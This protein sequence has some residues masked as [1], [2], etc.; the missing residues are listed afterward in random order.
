LE[1]QYDERLIPEIICKC[2]ELFSR[3]LTKIVI[4][5]AGIKENAIETKNTK[6]EVFLVPTDA[7]LINVYGKGSL[8]A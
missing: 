3:S 4:K 2:F 1:I 8:F 7:E 5:L 6:F